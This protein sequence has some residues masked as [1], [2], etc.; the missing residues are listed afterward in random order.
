[1]HRGVGILAG[2]LCR[3]KR[4]A[5]AACEGVSFAKGIQ[6]LSANAP[7]SVRAEGRAAIP[8]IPARRLHQADQTPGDEVFAIG[9]AAAR[10]DGP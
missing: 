6:D 9:A 3:P 1:V 8:A 10:I 5:C 4:T 7:R 2:A